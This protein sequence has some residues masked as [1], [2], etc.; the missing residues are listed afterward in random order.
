M[1]QHRNAIVEHRREEGTMNG[2]KTFGIFLIVTIL[3]LAML[4]SKKQTSPPSPPAKSGVDI[5]RETLDEK[6]QTKFRRILEGQL[7][8]K[9]EGQRIYVN[10]SWYGLTVDQKQ[11]AVFMMAVVYNMDV[12]HVF[13]GY[14]A[15][16]LGLFD[17]N[18]GGWH[19]RG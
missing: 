3:V 5:A 15:N 18:H 12:I 6:E 11:G 16:R 9:R 17:K 14:S 4:G 13:D 2:T 8:V 19:Q 10:R 7:I 1:R